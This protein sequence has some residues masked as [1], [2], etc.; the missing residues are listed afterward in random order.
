MSRVV[1][2]GAETLADV[3][4]FSDRLT[5]RTDGILDIGG[6]AATELLGRFGSPLVVGVEETLLANFD[7]IRAAFASAWPG[8]SGILYAI[9]SNNTLAFRHL[10]SRAGAGGDC[11]GMGELLATLDSGADP[12]RVAL[13]GSDKS[14]EL[15]RVAVA[16]G[17]T[18]N[19]DDADEVDMIADGASQTGRRARVNLRLKVL[20]EALGPFMGGSTQR[21]GQGIASAKRAKWGLSPEAATDIAKRLLRMP[22]IDLAGFSVHIGHLSNRPEA[23]AAIAAEFGAAVL[24][25]CTVLSL[26]PRILDL[27]G[28]WA[29]ER[30]PEQRGAP[31]D[32]VSVEEQANAACDALIGALGPLADPA[33]GPLPA[34]WVEPGRYISGNAEVLLTTVGSV[35]EDCGYLWVN[36][37]I[38]TNDLMRIE[39]G[40]FT[41]EILPAN[42]MH[43]APT[44]SQEIVGSTCFRS[45]IGAGRTLPRLRRGDVLAVLD[46][47]MYAEV[48][49]TQFNSVPRPAAV[50]IDPDGE[51]EVMRVRET[52]DDVFA[53]HRVPDR[54]KREEKE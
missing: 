12:A 20:P 8:S 50:L 32:W 16:R 38:S 21:H 30:E 9:K 35:K 14:A 31:I 39:T 51:V 1:K 27:G 24:Q 42:R 15:I 22:G 13:N 37:D 46:A 4:I 44:S 6:V 7:R 48:F 17:V 36:V 34:L 25:I 45:V 26:R 33:M 10:L 40:A 43:D 54:L 19:I 41:Y 28:G 5:A 49:S 53:S 47:G 52:Q 2:T 29:R 18:I 11:F 23:F 3:E